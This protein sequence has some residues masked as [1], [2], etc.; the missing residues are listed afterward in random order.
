MKKLKIL[1]ILLIAGFVALRRLRRQAFSR[2]DGWFFA[3]MAVIDLGLTMY[4]LLIRLP[5]NELTIQRVVRFEPD[6]GLMFLVI[7][8]LTVVWGSIRTLWAVQCWWRT[9]ITTDI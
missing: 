8:L 1:L 6:L 2:Q 7:L 5:N 3:G 4:F 9:R